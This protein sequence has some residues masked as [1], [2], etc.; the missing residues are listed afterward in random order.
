[1]TQQ[2]LQS[3]FDE[4]AQT[5]DAELQTA[6]NYF[7]FEGY[8]QVL[9]TIWRQARATPGMSILDLGVGTGNLA[10]YFLDAGC[11]VLGADFSAEMLAKA[12]A[13]FPNLQ[14]I[15]A[16]LT[17]DEW[18]AVLNRRFD[19]IVSNYVFHEFPFA[20][21][22]G[23]LERLARQHLATEG[24][25]VVGD[26]AFPTNY[27]LHETRRRAG[28]RWDEEYYWIL[29]Q[30]RAALEPAGWRVGY[31]QISFCAAVYTFSPPKIELGAGGR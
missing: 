26:I 5:Y 21:K 12:R 8:E 29:D 23:L 16:N 17:L 22:L 27:A 14:L 10:R 11:S 2:D 7:P 1:M 28:E 25:I 30:T 6:G 20:T 31:Q 19:R 3:Q 18:P 15:Q 9:Q 13:K 24:F 4:W